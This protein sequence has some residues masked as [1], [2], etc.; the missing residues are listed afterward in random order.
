[1]PENQSNEAPTQIFIP[2]VSAEGTPAERIRI[3][4][5]FI[6]DA[7]GSMKPLQKQ[8]IAGFN[9]Q[10]QNI[11]QLE[12]QHPNQ[13]QLV[14]LAVFNGSP[15]IRFF[16]TSSISL[17]E[18]TEA[19]YSPNGSTNLYGTVGE[20]VTR[21]K[22][23]LGNRCN[24]ERVII[25]IMTDG[26][27]TDHSEWTQNRVAELLQQVQADYSWVVTFIGANINV[28]QAA[29]QLNIPV[30]NTAAYTASASS[31]RRAFA[32]SARA[33]SSYLMSMPALGEAATVWYL[34]ADLSRGLDLTDATAAANAAAYVDDPTL[35][36]ISRRVPTP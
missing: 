24:Q 6:L 3:H 17:Q 15:N 36:P 10:V 23:T 30:S 26:E 11:R 1:M 29:Q 32:E 8:T 31:T 14:T 27:N 34:S 21:L 28:T 4:H 2:G 25:T 13:E 5:V 12:Q 19:D 18:I 33:R 22:N 35:R 16:D 20:V 9:E 7:S